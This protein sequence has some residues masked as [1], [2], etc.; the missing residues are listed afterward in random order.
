[1]MRWDDENWREALREIIYW[2]LNAN[3]SPRG[4]DAG[5][6]LTQAAIERLSYEYAVKDKK[7]IEAKGFKDLRASDKFRLLF[8][9]L[10]ISIDIPTTVPELKKLAKRFNWL[11][12]PHAMTEVRNT[13]VHPE[14]KQRGQFRSAIYETW[15]LGL[16]YLELSLL[17]IC[18]YSGTYSNRLVSEWV[19]QVEDV[20][21]KK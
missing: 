16:W 20:P 18:G 19:G 3:Y 2:Y 21:W 9:S 7:L 17:R 12:A 1:M 15:N 4:I 8:S 13:L 6:I 11:D 14:H 5:I 10:D